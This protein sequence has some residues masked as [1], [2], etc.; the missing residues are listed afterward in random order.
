[1]EGISNAISICVF[2]CHSRKTVEEYA[3]FISYRL[4][5][6][7]EPKFEA[8]NCFLNSKCGICDGEATKR[9][10]ELQSDLYFISS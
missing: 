2:P 6:R 7:E 9:R 8:V 3:V 1:M 10:L 4:K 5:Q